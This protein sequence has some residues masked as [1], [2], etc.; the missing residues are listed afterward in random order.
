MKNLSTPSGRESRIG[1]PQGTIEYRDIGEGPTIVFVHGLFMNGK[2]YSD[3][4]DLVSKTHRCIVPEWPLG[5][6]SRALNADADLSPVGAARL[7]ADFLAAL[8]LDAVTLVGLDFGA[9]V[10]QIVGA[11][12]NSR[13][14]QIVLHNCDALEV[15]PAKGFEYLGWLPRMPGAMWMLARAM[16]HIRLLREHPTSYGVFAQTDLP[17]DLLLEWV[18][19]MK[20]NP[21][22]RRDVAKMLRGISKELT[23]QLPAELRETGLPVSLVWGME[24]TLFTI[25]L[26]RRLR[27]AI[28]ESAQLFEIPDAKTFVPFDAPDRVADALRKI[29][30]NV[31]P[32]ESIREFD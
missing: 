21:G 23:L 2:I 32:S 1:V 5:S 13:I 4:V 15:F 24:D 19:P 8:D 26:A 14:A 22:V 11:R 31:L 9:V 17:A 20:V 10:V 12:F 6:H 25:D 28:G 16:F 7:V 18:R 30:Q 3:V 29:T 27:D